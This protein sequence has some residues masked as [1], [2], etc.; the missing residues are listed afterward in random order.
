MAFLKK[1]CAGDKTRVTKYVQLYLTTIKP[2]I[3]KLNIALETNNYS[4]IKTIIHSIK[5]QFIF[6]GMEVNSK[7]VILIEKHL[8]E[9]PINIKFK[10]LVMELIDHCYRSINELS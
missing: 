8:D 3:K 10:P 2:T 5:P 7:L 1:F 9:K 4:S 6:M